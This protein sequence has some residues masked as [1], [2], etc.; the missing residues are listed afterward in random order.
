[1]GCFLFTG[2]K[3]LF[4]KLIATSVVVQRARTGSL[5]SNSSSVGIVVVIK[6]LGEVRAANGMRFGYFALLEGLQLILLSNLV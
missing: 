3:F 6:A 1:M 4:I 5:G 2:T